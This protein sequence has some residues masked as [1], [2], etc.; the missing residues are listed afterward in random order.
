MGAGF[1]LL[2]VDSILRLRGGGEGGLPSRLPGIAHRRSAHDLT[3]YPHKIHHSVS[4]SIVNNNINGSGG[5][6]AKVLRGLAQLV[7]ELF[8]S[9]AYIEVCGCV[10]SPNYADNS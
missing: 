2:I 1:S 5:G 6:I 10:H 8:Y 4:W 3:C 9:L 7:N